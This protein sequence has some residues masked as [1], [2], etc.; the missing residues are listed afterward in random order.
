MRHRWKFQYVVTIS[1]CDNAIARAFDLHR[2]TYQ[3]ISLGINHSSFYKG[4]T[5][6]LHIFNTSRK[7]SLKWGGQ[8]A[9]SWLKLLPRKATSF[10]SSS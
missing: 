1:I 3:R 2:D 9:Q 5:F 7:T 4:M 10:F 6:F 8:P